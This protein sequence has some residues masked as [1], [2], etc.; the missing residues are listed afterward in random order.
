MS[1]KRTFLAP[2]LTALALLAG[3]PVASAQIKC[4]TNSE[5]VRECG[6]VVPPEY[7]QQGHAEVSEQGLT[8]ETV[9][10][11]KTAE[12]LAAQQQAE[13]EAAERK[14]LAEEQA[15]K[16]RIL[17]DTFAGED[18]VKL[19]RDGKITNIDS[20]IRLT[21]DHI[22]KLT[23]NMNALIAEAGELERAGSPVPEGLTRDIEA[24]R[25]QIAEQQA[26]IAKKRQDQE[27]IR[28]EYEGYLQRI[29]ELKGT[30]AQS[31]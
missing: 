14:R 28:V 13:R 4:W 16:D 30:T 18:D 5:G 24:V 8:R 19:A 10:P 27:D 31:P 22:G 9:A 15:R 6:N 29:R 20:Q 7:A 17:L 21:E 1:A 25:T 12:E 23:A 2:T 26:F 3:A 11:A